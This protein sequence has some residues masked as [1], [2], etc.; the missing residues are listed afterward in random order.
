[1]FDWLK[2]LS[3]CQILALSFFAIGKLVGI[4]SILSLLLVLVSDAY[5]ALLVMMLIT[6]GSFITLSIVFSIMDH[7]SHNKS[8]N[9]TFDRVINDPEFREKIFRD[10]KLSVDKGA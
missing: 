7:F 10:M 8:I 5:R 1:M 6:Y 9:K 4:A 2:N 3:T